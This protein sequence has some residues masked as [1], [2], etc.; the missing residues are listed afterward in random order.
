MDTI[1]LPPISGM[2][3]G[4]QINQ[5]GA[6]PRSGRTALDVNDF[7]RLLAA[8]LSNQDPMNPMKDTEF[9]AQLANFTSLEQTRTM[10]E[11]LQRF[12]TEQSIAASAAFIGKEVTVRPATGSDITGVV[13]AVTIRNGRPHVIVNNQ[14]YEMRLI[15]S[16]GQLPPDF[17]SQASS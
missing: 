6:N 3:P 2:T 7:M 17:E 14:T 1:S 13:Q 16:V 10:S 11:A 4:Q 8:Q 9:I 5:P 15:S 12:T